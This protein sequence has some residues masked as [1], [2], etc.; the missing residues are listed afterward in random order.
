MKKSVEMVKEILEI[1]FDSFL[2]S[3]RVVV[4]LNPKSSA[5]ITRMKDQAKEKGMLVDATHGK[6]T[7]SV[8]VMDTGHIVLSSIQAR[9]LK[10][11]FQK[12]AEK[13]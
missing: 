11:K 2:F 7:R 6:P 13:P 1:G 4:V 8:I 3:S 12:K 9:T 5:P 10:A